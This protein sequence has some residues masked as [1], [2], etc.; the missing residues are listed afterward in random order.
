MCRE[1]LEIRVQKLRNPRLVLLDIPTD[2]TLGNV[3]EVLMQQ[4]RELK[5]NNGNIE[6]KFCYIAKRTRNLV[7]EVDSV[8]RKKLLQTRV[9]LGWASCKID[10]YV[11]AKRCFRC[12]RYNHTYKECKG[13]ETCTLCTGNHKLKG[14]SAVRW[15]LTHIGLNRNYSTHNKCRSK[16][17]LN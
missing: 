16:Q 5:I 15:E 17:L 4:N 7:I 6:P 12:S 10:D 13:E 11:I 8:T 2:I 9:K 3:K 14:F 1:E